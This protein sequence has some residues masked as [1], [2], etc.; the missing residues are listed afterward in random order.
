MAK[1]RAT[2]NEFTRIAFPYFRGSDR[3]WGRGLLLVVIALQLFQ[4]WLNVRFN[5]WYN[6]FYTALQD[7]NWEVFIYQFGVFT[8][9]AIF[10]IVTAVYQLYL[11]QWLQIR[12]RGWLT[13]AYLGLWPAEGTHYR[14]RLK[15]DS[16]D[17]PDQR[18][19]DDIRLF[20][21]GTLD[22]GIALLGSVV[23]LISFIVI[24]FN[25]ALIAAALERLRGGDGSTGIGRRA[26]H[27]YMTTG[28][29]TATATASAPRTWRNDGRAHRLLVQA[30]PADDAV[31]L[32]VEAVDAEAFEATVARLRA[33]GLDVLEGDGTERRV[34]RLVR[35][36]APW[37][38][39]V[40]V[41]SPGSRSQNQPWS[42]TPG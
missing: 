34:E 14:M 31:A 22:I 23:T 41:V 6:T 9:L 42:I 17:N 27:T 18:I 40:E 10:F 1:F 26:R 21:N 16:A 24:F 19:A 13:E 20:V 33:T 39:D 12:W 30:G 32:G 7:K 38:V 15:G 4:V 35:T 5:A 36:A 28:T 2:A 25:S 37:G 29:H 11:Q 8:V 3:W